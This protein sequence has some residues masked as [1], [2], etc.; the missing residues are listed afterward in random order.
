[1]IYFNNN[2]TYNDICPTNEINVISCFLSN[3]KLSLC[4]LLKIN[5]FGL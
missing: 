3:K 4:D 5:Q 1:M 2:L